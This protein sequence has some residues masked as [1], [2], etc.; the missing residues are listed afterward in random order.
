MIGEIDIKDIL[1]ITGL[2][3]TLC[4]GL[5]N[6]WFNW[7]ISK[8]S[9]FVNTV[10]SERIKW[11]SQVRDRLAELLSVCEQWMMHRTQ[12]RTPNLQSQI[13]TLRAELRLLLNPLD[14]EDVDVERLLLRL[15]DW[16]NSMTPEDFFAIRELLIIACKSM[17]KREWDKIK[18]ESEKGRIKL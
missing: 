13:D 14:Q 2:L 11:I 1:V 15:P 8:R 9:S 17:L 5:F 18:D 3:I 12:E 10:T 6:L 4:L 16:H 7:H